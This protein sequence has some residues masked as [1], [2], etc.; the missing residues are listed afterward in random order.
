MRID[1]VTAF[2]YLAESPIEESIIKRARHKKLVDINIHDLR[3][4]TS[5]KHHKFDDYP[6]GGGPGMVIKPE[7][8]FR[9]VDH[10]FKS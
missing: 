2:H 3:E 9:C 4:F 5:D 7:P 1:L 10:I 6:Y 8:F